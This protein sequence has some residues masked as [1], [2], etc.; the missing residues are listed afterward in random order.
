MNNKEFFDTATLQYRPKNMTQK[1]RE[2]ESG[3]RYIKMR[4][5]FLAVFREQNQTIKSL[6]L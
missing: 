6:K 5:E 1:V 4:Q 3:E 2:F